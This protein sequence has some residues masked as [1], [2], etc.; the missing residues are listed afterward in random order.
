M[1]GRMESVVYTDCLPGESLSGNPGL[2]VQSASSGA[3]PAARDLVRAHVL[4][5]PPQE[6]M[7]Q[8]RAVEDYPP[9]LAHLYSDDWYV[10]ARGI[11][12]GKEAKGNREG[13]HLTHAVLSRDDAN[14]DFIRPA[15]MHDAAWWRTE[16][17]PTSD[18]PAI[19]AGWEPG[20]LN[21]DDIAQFVTRLPNGE[22][23]VAALLTILRDETDQRRIIIVGADQAD[24]VRLIAAV[25][26]LLPQKVA[27][28]VGFRVYAANPT[29]SLHRICGVHPDLASDHYPG[30]HVVDMAEGSL[31]E[32][33]EPTSDAHAWVRLL[34][35]EDPY[36]VVD[37]VELA[38]S[39]D[40]GPQGTHA[41]ACAAYFGHI[42]D[43][44]WAH[45]LAVWVR[46]SREEHCGAYGN[47]VASTLL[48]LEN[49]DVDMLRV[50]D[51][52]AANGRLAG[53]ASAIRLAL[54]DAELLL[55]ELGDPQALSPLPVTEWTSD[56][57]QRATDIVVAEL[58]TASGGRFVH[59]LQLSSRYSLDPP[60]LTEVG[61]AT[62]HK[63][64]EY[65]HEH[66]HATKI[67]AS[68]PLGSIVLPHLHQY[69][70][71]QCRDTERAEYLG[72][73]WGHT[74]LE[75][76]PNTDFDDP[77]FRVCV[78][79]AMQSHTYAFDA[80]NRAWQSAGPGREAEMVNLLWRKRP[81][82]MAEVMWMALRIS[83]GAR[84]DQH[85]FRAVEE[86]FRSKGEPITLD[87]LDSLYRLVQYQVI[88]NRN[89]VNLAA[90]D[91]DVDL[92][93]R[94]NP[95]GLV[96]DDMIRRISKGF[97]AYPNVMARFSER[98]VEFLAKEGGPTATLKILHHLRAHDQR[99]Y[100]SL[101]SRRL[102]HPSARSL[103]N[104]W[105]VNRMH[106]KTSEE[107]RELA[108]SL[109]SALER[110]PLKELTAATN[111]LLQVSLKLGSDFRAMRDDLGGQKS[112]SLVN[113]ALYKDGNERA[114]GKTRRL[115]RRW[116]KEI[117]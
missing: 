71:E 88:T 19:D 117:L 93:L 1:T 78:G 75:W 58:A 29:R 30:M 9:M 96:Y 106:S 25:T 99:I 41:L 84:V 16:K 83:P 107:N 65:W 69:L 77:M 35:T 47:A 61:S 51:Q 74:Y 94:D 72:S 60:G 2:G 67:V 22:W 14:F 66:P 40:F 28:Q 114:V 81:A 103:A 53:L 73:L 64:C 4:Y 42:P 52:A 110:A 13:N 46:E 95:D 105:V 104:A 86:R 98:L 31:A 36:D 102:H 80:M 17:N 5:E 116:R 38:A 100:L 59:L 115:S 92:F 111:L 82:S 18:A 112:K 85:I 87:E 15:Q 20:P 11:Y 37:A 45:I 54:L 39:T 7:R 90:L 113:R 56:S 91:K 3:E 44:N 6:W 68:S 21:A 27:L 57:E 109:V 32:P 50:L 97:E 10:T 48:S 26:L 33:V 34:C 49:P 24:I 101:L 89:L 108:R 76:F 8:G 12:L 43:D 23:I 55:P 62:L 79:E 70:V 63:L